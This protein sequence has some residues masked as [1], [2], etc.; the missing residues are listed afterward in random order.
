ME[1][2]LTERELRAQLLAHEPDVDTVRMFTQQFDRLSP[3]QQFDYADSTLSRI[4]LLTQDPFLKASLSRPTNLLNFRTLIDNNQS[5]ILNLDVENGGTERLLGCLI[6]V[7]AEKGAST[8]GTIAASA[9]HGSHHLVID[10]FQQFAATS[11]AAL[12]DM[13][14]KTRKY[15]LF[16]VMAHQSWSQASS[17]LRGGLQNVGLEVVFRLGRQ[18]AEYSAM[19]L[20]RVSTEAVK[21]TVTDNTA[22]GR[23]H[24]VFYSLAEQWEAWV[25][26]IQDLP[27]RHALMRTPAGAIATV[28]S[29]SIPDPVVDRGELAE[30]E[31]EYL[32]RYFHPRPAPAELPP[33]S[34][35]PQPAPPSTVRKRRLTAG[36]EVSHA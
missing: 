15:G 26:Q 2:F 13:L 16:L 19:T 31:A 36:E 27:T 21:H 5:V 23:T 25:Q 12:N 14:S 24:P 32:A 10:E 7:L 22:A 1:A 20:G 28:R 17:R 11:E 3:R 8:R 30:V 6:T 4:S 35:P 33:A 29:L 34:A 9:R 18:D